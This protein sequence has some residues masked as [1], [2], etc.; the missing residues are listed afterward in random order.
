MTRPARVLVVGRHADLMDRVLAL[1]IADGHDAFGA[2]TD[3]DAIARVTEDAPDLVV[4]GGGVEPASRAAIAAAVHA[5]APGRP[6]IVH[7]G[8]PHGLTAAIR[9]ALSLLDDP[10]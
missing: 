7:R 5:V 2:L 3:E 8:G 6:V 4:V 10:A 9:D 1:V